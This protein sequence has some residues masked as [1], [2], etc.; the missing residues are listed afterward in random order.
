MVG[1]SVDAATHENYMYKQQKSESSKVNQQPTGR[2]Y[3]VQPLSPS[4][5]SADLQ[6]PGEGIWMDKHSSHVVNHDLQP[7]VGR[8]SLPRASCFVIISNGL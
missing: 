5:A 4:P 6:Q 1:Y 2:E 7:G 3:Q 8:E